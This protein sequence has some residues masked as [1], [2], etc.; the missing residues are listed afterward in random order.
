[1]S[2]R[3]FSISFSSWVPAGEDGV[4]PGFHVLWSC[5]S[6]WG[7]EG[8]RPWGGGRTWN[9]VGS[10]QH[11]L[12]PIPQESSLWSLL[13]KFHAVYL[14]KW[15]GDLLTLQAHTVFRSQLSNLLAIAVEALGNVPGLWLRRW[16]K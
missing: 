2:F 13:K 1:M 16:R 11:W 12:T 6:E 14:Q 5:V 10:L 4:R 9:S 8:R 15:D 7:W 3:M